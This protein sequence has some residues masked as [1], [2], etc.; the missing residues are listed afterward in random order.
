M[1]LI[2][3][4]EFDRPVLIVPSRTNSTNAS[5]SFVTDESSYIANS[6]Q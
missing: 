2:V 1:K 3:K 6:F 5:L 4:L